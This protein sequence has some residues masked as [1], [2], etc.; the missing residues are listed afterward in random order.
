MTDPTSDPGVSCQLIGW[1]HH[2]HSCLSHGLP[3][4]TFAQTKTAW[5]IPAGWVAKNWSREQSGLK[6]PHMTQVCKA[7]HRDSTRNT[8]TQST[9]LNTTCHK[10]EQ[11]IAGD[12]KGNRKHTT[13]ASRMVMLCC[14]RLYGLLLQLGGQRRCALLLLAAAA[15]LDAATGSHSRRDRASVWKV[16]LL[17]CDSVAATTCLRIQTLAAA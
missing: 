12:Q 15:G 7:P 14:T 13:A 6:G 2:N 9:Q 4:G 17:V 8:A 3:E 1:R 11:T 16:P 10:R 5:L